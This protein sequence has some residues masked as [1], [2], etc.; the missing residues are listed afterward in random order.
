MTRKPQMYTEFLFFE[1]LLYKSSKLKAITK[2]AMNKIM[3]FF[4]FETQTYEKT[5]IWKLINCSKNK[6][7]N[8]IIPTLLLVIRCKTRIMIGFCGFD[9]N[10]LPLEVY[11][12]YRL[13]PSCFYIP[14]TIKM[15]YKNDGKPLFFSSKKRKQNQSVFFLPV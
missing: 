11:C 1:K 5:N 4:Y 6:N 10:T 13:W 7:M 15:M 14:F 9:I 2:N 12:F 8:Y 3:S